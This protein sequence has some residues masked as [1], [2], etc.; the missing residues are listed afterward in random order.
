MEA[1]SFGFRKK[2]KKYKKLKLKKK[3]NIVISDSQAF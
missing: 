2:T 3:N 1:R